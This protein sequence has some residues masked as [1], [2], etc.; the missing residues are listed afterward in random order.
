MGS[1]AR[2][3]VSCFGVVVVAENALKTLSR[4]QQQ[5]APVALQRTFPILV[6]LT[7]AGDK[8]AREKMQIGE[9][10]LCVINSVN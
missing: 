5:H 7:S 6:L 2:C 3:E 1:A 10:F 4:R 9:A 8:T